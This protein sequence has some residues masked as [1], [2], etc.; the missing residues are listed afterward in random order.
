MREDDERSEWRWMMS[1]SQKNEPGW[2]GL[3]IE[4]GVFAWLAAISC[5]AEHDRAGRGAERGSVANL[6]APS[7]N[8]LQVSPHGPGCV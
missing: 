3:F 1:D 5:V 7:R 4:P 8:S 6:D 2:S